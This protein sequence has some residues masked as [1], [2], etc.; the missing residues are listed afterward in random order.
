MVAC[1]PRTLPHRARTARESNFTRPSSPPGGQTRR[2]SKRVPTAVVA[3]CG[4]HTQ[5]KTITHH[6]HQQIVYHQNKNKTMVLYKHVVGR[7]T[8]YTRY[9]SRVETHISHPP[10]R[11]YRPASRR[12]NTLR[13]LPYINTTK[14]QQ[15]DE[16]CLVCS[17]LHSRIRRTTP[18]PPF[19]GPLPPRGSLRGWRTQTAAHYILPFMTS[20][21]LPF[22]GEN[23]RN[24]LNTTHP[25]DAATRPYDYCIHLVGT[26]GNQ[27]HVP[28][29]PP[30]TPKLPRSEST[31]TH[32]DQPK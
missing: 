22:S 17:F 7:S 25:A 2:D 20:P 29:T 6:T 10:G 18:P 3:E 5:R 8:M 26:E 31:N 28:T 23:V 24:R 27:E 12:T 11:R 9:P 30:K 19:F 13:L 15:Q 4:K 21:R 16:E 1:R 32:I 14:Y